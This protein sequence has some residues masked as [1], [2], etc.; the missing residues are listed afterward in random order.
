MSKEATPVFFH[1]PHKGVSVEGGPAVTRIYTVHFFT[2]EMDYAVPGEIHPFWEMI[3]MDSGSI[4]LFGDGWSL[5]LPEG[6]LMLI[7][8][9]RPHGFRTKA[10]QMYNMFIMSFDCSRA[11][12]EKFAGQRIF[13]ATPAVKQ[14]IG[15]IVR[16]AR[17]SFLYPLDR[18]SAD[19]LKLKKNA[20]PS[21]VQIIRRLSELLLLQIGRTEADGQYFTFDEAP[22][23]AHPL[24]AKAVQYLRQN[25]D[26]PLTMDKLCTHVG[27]SASH[28]QKLFKRDVG[29][30]IMQYHRCL[31]I[32]KTKYLIRRQT[33]TMSEIAEKAGFSSIH[34]F[35]T[36]FKQV[37]HLSPTQYADTVKKWM[38]GVSGE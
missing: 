36:C 26:G 38:D 37:E 23:R 1:Y 21:C 9:D 18:I 12:M 24:V 4:D 33:Y 2:D 13:D 14:L 17:Q 16:Q 19:Q 28:L 8:P 27:A 5:T 32:A 3:Y 11:G 30:T 34:H 6:G 35:S 29:T 31:R 20:D 10:G 7:E 15:H 22:L 25:V